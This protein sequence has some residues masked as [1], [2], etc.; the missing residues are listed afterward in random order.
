MHLSVTQ[1]GVH[2][3]FIFYLRM[4]VFVVHQTKREAAYFIVVLHDQKVVVIT[5]RGTETP[6]DLLT[7]GLCRE[8][9]LSMA[10]LDGLIKKVSLCFCAFSSFFLLFVR[11]LL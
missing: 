7:D 2:H 1:S 3:I 8:C 6:E 9:A 11:L 5:V 10:D 4:A